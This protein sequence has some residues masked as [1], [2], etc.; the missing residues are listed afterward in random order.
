MGD[1]G[2]RAGPGQDLRGGSEGRG[3]SAFAGLEDDEPEAAA[4]AGLELLGEELDLDP[5]LLAIVVVSEP[6]HR[7]AVLDPSM[8]EEVEHVRDGLTAE[9][10]EKAGDAG[11]WRFDGIEP[12]DLAGG[13]PL[14]ERALQHREAG[15]SRG[16]DREDAQGAADLAGLPWLARGHAAYGVEV[17]GAGQE[18][19][20]FAGLAECLPGDR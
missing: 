8:T 13:D 20:G 1:D 12:F 15:G 2:I 6:E 3:P 11:G 10:L 17:R 9:A 14:V 16:R 4:K 5:A 18:A 19:H 7:F